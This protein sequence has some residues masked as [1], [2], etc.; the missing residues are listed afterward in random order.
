MC[1]EFV[2]A[3]TV[4]PISGHWYVTGGGAAGDGQSDQ[5]P[6]VHEANAVAPLIKK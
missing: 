2:G 1:H 3:Q 4:A 6:P 5:T